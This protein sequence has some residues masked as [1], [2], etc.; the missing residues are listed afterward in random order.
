[1][2]V[3]YQTSPLLP[4]PQSISFLHAK[5]AGFTTSKSKP[6]LSVGL[7]GIFSTSKQFMLVLRAQWK[8][9]MP[10]SMYDTLAS[11]SVLHQPQT[12]QA[13]PVQ[14]LSSVHHVH[15][16]MCAG[17]VLDIQIILGLS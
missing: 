10:A 9:H 12:L 15:P 2:P 13:I 4:S 7:E 16:G 14:Q 17:A 8:K 1:M 3:A 6:H 11:T 5:T